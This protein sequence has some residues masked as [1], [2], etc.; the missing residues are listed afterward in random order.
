MSNPRIDCLIVGSGPVGLVAAC[1]LKQYGLNIRIIDKLNGPVLRNK[2]AVVWART[3]EFLDQM[4]LADQFT[5]TGLKCYGASL[6]ADGKRFAQIPLDGTDSLFN[7][8]LMIPQHKTERILREH[9]KSLGT[10]VEYGV[11]LESITDHPHCATAHLASGESIESNWIVGCDGAHSGVRHALGLPFEGEQLESF[12]MVADLHLDGLP[13]D[14]EVMAFLH[15]DGPTALFPLGDNFFRAVAQISSV[16][17]PRDR[18][19]AKADITHVLESRIGGSLQIV[20]IRRAG[21]FT[22]HQRQVDQYRQGRVFLAGDSAHIHSPLGGQGMNTGMHDAN[23][24]AWKLAMVC[25]G[26]MRPELLDTYHEERYPIGHWLVKSTSI[27]TKM[28]TNRQPIVAALRIQA[29]KFLA[30]IPMVQSKVRDTL[31]EI[32]IHYRDSSLSLE[33]SCPVQNWRFRGGIRA[34][35]RAEDAPVREGDKQGRLKDYIYGCRYHLLLF[36]GDEVDA[37]HDLELTARLIHKR[38]GSAV[39]IVWVGLNDA[40]PKLTFDARYLVDF[41]EQLHEDYAAS[42]STVYLVRPDGYVAYRSQPVDHEELEG[43]LLKWFSDE[44]IPA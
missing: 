38:F 13:L 19:Q 40:P 26:H 44:T 43:H 31:S 2:A 28:V 14:D 11:E 39:Q 8:A 1:Q 24:L 20:D 10:E 15:H 33:P 4:G 35:E 36:K 6:F 25:Q 5:S 32:E 16:E 9:L 18:A 27:A 22:I 34:G 30:N 37:W 23:N 12:W 17:D 7:F 29:A 42:G 21:Y 3:C 41:T